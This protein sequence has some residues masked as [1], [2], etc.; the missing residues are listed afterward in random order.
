MITY[1]KIL[2]QRDN[3]YN[4]FADKI[5]KIKK[6]IINCIK[7]TRNIKFLV[8]SLISTEQIWGDEGHLLK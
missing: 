3:N 5:C 8:S 6:D 2:S 4:M 1:N 7:K